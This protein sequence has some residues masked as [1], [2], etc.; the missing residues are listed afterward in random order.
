MESGVHGWNRIRGAW[1]ESNLE[2]RNTNF[3]L[4]TPS[5][6]VGFGEGFDNAIKCKYLNSPKRGFYVGQFKKK[7]KTGER[8]TS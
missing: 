3:N 6:S 2:N 7:E 8:I 1:L 4:V 5:F